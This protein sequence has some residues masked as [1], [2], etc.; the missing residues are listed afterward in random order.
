MQN[1]FGSKFNTVF[2]LVLIALM[3]VVIVMMKRS[4][5]VDLSTLKQNDIVQ[6][7]EDENI[8]QVASTYTYINHGFG[9]EF[10]NGFNP[11]EKKSESG[12]AT[13]IKLPDGILNYWSDASLWEKH[14]LP[15]Y[16]YAKDQKIGTTLFKAYYA[17]PQGS[18][19]YWFKQGNVGYEFIDV[20]LK[21]LETFYFIGWP[22]IEGVKENLVSFSIKPGQKV[23]GLVH[24]VG[25]LKGNYFFEGSLP[26]T[27]LDANK[28]K[29]SYGPGYAKVTSDWM[30]S[31]PVSFSFDID[32]T[33]VPKGKTYIEIKK[34]DPRDESEKGDTPPTE[35]FIPIMIK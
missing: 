7:T 27:I 5:E 9:I 3:V 15:K 16:V 12:P 23:S 2:L 18:S 11:T 6:K 17:E 35:I 10:P 25:S 30:T 22:Q 28:K 21:L 33:N 1:R 31:G 14:S 4:Q 8:A 19:I 20:D 26:I 13:I 34:D 24:V 29:T 32:F